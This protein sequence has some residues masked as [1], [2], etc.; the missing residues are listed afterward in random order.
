M[1]EKLDGI[2]LRTQDYGETHKIVTILTPQL[3]KIGAIARGAK[4]PKSRMAAITQPFIHAQFLIQL[5]SSLATIQQGEVIQSFRKIRE[6]IILTAYASYLAELTDKLLDQKKYR[7]FLYKQLLQTF[8]WFAEGKDPEILVMIYE[9]KMYK[10]AGFAPVVMQCV[11]CGNSNNLH[12]FSVKNG[13][14]LCLNCTGMDENAYSL[15]A[16]VI[17]LLQIFSEVDIDR[18][19][20]IKVKEENKQLL[21]LLME[22]YYEQY[23][24]YY[25]KTKKFLKQLDLLK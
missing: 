20:L 18:I 21:H 4:K 19:G 17:K 24:G 5:G 9:W 25:L 8:D 16:N 7:P 15:N 10:E 14:M 11:N 23:G 3:G 13:G 1:F 2:I 22:D 6:D 12:A